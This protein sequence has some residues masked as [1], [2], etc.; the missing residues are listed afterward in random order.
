MSEERTR[1]GPRFARLLVAGGL[2]NLGDGVRSAALPLVAAGLTRDPLA[3][4]TVAIAGTLPWLVLSLPAGVIVDRVERRRLMVGANVVRALLLAGLGLALVADRGSV[5]LLALVALGLGS[6]E[7]LFDNAAQTLLPSLVDPAALERANGRLSSAEIVT[8]QFA[9][10]PLGGALFAF[11]VAL[12]VLVD[13]GLLAAAAVLVAGLPRGSVPAPPPA[14]AGGSDAAAPVTRGFV[15]DLR[16]GVAWLARHRLLRTLALLLAVLNGTGA[17]GMAVFA[18]YATGEGSILGLGPLGFSLLMTAGSAGA[19]AASLVADRLVECMGRAR[20]LWASLVAFVVAPLGFAIAGGVALV[21]VASILTAG[22]GV[23]WN[24]ITVSLRQT[25]IPDRLLGR[26]NS[27]YR[28][29]GWGAMPIGAAIG[30]AVARVGGL[31]A[32]W[33]LAAALT[34]AALPFAAGVVRGDVIEA[35]RRETAD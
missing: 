14:S 2:S 3:F 15:A 17:M 29:L 35:A 16:E 5:A 9:G 4:S 30:G 6:C 18:L 26:V 21:V 10:P 11:A 31:R 24:V 34:A 12:P 1:L 7:V 23:V 19:L 8:N 22:M 13:A 20:A 25:V 28:F 27:A 32:P 33:W